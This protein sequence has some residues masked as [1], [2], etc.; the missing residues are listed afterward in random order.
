[1]RPQGPRECIL[2]FVQDN[3]DVNPQQSTVPKSLWRLTTVRFFY[4]CLG[5]S[6][7]S[8]TLW[9]QRP[10]WH[11]TR[12]T[13]CLSSLRFVAPSCWKSFT[14]RVPC[15]FPTQQATI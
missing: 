8:A 6:G 1:M 14:S 4:T 13:D 15:A 9:G 10:L 5:L 7:S 3:P 2:L 11:A 12:A